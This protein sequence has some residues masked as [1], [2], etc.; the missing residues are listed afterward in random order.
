[1]SR[2]L[3][4]SEW[5]IVYGYEQRKGTGIRAKCRAIMSNEGKLDRKRG[6][7]IP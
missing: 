2:G 5:E 7:S 3:T 1:M 6:F 4:H